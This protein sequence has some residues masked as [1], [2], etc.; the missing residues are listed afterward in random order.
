MSMFV[1]MRR[2]FLGNKHIDPITAGKLVNGMLS[3]EQYIA[4]SDQSRIVFIIGASD[5]LNQLIRFSAPRSR[6]LLVSMS[7]YA[8]KFSA[9]TLRD[10]FDQ[11]LRDDPR[12]VDM[13][14]ANAYFFFLAECARHEYGL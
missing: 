13:F 10:M 4:S 2:R 3:G 6:V 8:A 5:M 12:R 1:W 9:G 14:A 7:K 11:Y